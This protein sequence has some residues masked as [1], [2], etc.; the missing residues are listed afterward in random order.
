[1]KPLRLYVLGQQGQVARALQEVSERRPDVVVGFGGRN[2]FDIADVD[3]VLAA[4]RDFRPDFVI[5]P[6]AYTAVDRAEEESA[7]AYHVNRDGAK[8]VAEASAC[9]EIP[10]IHLS[11]DYVFDGT[12]STP[13]AEDDATA[14]MSVYGASKLAG[15][16]A[17]AAANHRHVILRT[18]WVYSPFGHNFVR[19]MLRLAETRDTLRVVCDQVGSPTYALDLAQAILAIAGR[20]DRSGWSTEFGGVTHI[21]GPDVVTWYDFACQIMRLAAARCARSA[22]VEPITTS[23]YP[24]PARRPRNSRLS[25][26][27]LTTVFGISMPPLEQSLSQCVSR[28]IINA[29]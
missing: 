3:A 19:T 25:C 28:L 7:V 21:A 17:V 22:K 29:D 15:E 1:M 14:P 11:T 12:K 2:D 20:I 13:Y 16:H 8:A 26:N 5:N 23:D 6:A 18:A 4:L 9:M 24:T 27:R 10:T